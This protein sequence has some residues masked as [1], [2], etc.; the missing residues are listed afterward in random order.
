MKRVSWSG[1]GGVTIELNTRQ[2][3]NVTRTVLLVIGVEEQRTAGF[4][5]VCK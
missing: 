3:V 5:L 2:S 4:S 1:E